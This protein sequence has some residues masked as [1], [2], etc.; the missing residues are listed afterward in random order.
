CCITAIGVFAL[1]AL[2]VLIPAI[3]HLPGRAVP[4][5]FFLLLCGQVGVARWSRI[6]LERRRVSEVKREHEQK[7]T[8]RREEYWRWKQLLRDRCPSEPEV[9]H[10]LDC[11]KTIFLDDALQYYGL[12]WQDII[13]HTVLMT[14][15]PKKA[16]HGPCRRRARAQRGPWRYTDYDMRLFL[17]T[18]DGVREVATQL[19]FNYGR[20]RGR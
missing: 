11:D 4:A 3:Q 19:D 1:T 13:A 9:E 15:L 5:T 12:K 7:M 14:R 2:L 20:M 16:Q 6:I 8:A 17:V 10:W 18:A